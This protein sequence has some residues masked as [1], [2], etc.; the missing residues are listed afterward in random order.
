MTPSLALLLRHQTETQRPV[1][2]EDLAAFNI[3]WDL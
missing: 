3:R 2:E 1:V